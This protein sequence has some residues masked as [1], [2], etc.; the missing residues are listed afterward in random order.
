[1]KELK[2]EIKTKDVIIIVVGTITG[3]FIAALVI[4]MFTDFTFADLLVIASTGSLIAISSRFLSISKTH[5][6]TPKE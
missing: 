6:I 5:N 4:G 3:G 1:M 2:S